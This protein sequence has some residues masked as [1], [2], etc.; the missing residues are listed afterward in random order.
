MLSG[1][2]LSSDEA[3]GGRPAYL[4]VPDD[5]SHSRVRGERAVMAGRPLSI[6][7]VLPPRSS[8]RRRDGIRGSAL[9]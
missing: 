7:M 9:P 4:R 8:L 6:R 1:R 2:V 5:A 3:L